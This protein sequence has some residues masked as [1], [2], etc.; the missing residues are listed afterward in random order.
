MAKTLAFIRGGLK[1]MDKEN[2]MYCSDYAYKDTRYWKC[3]SVGCNVR[4]KTL[5]LERQGPVQSVSITG[6]HPHPLNP[7]EHKLSEAKIELKTLAINSQEFSHTVI[8]NVL[9]NTSKNIKAIIPSNANFTRNVRHIRAVNSMAPPN[10]SSKYGSRFPKIY[11]ENP[12]AR[13]SFY[14]ILASTTWTDF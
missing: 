12:R 2:Y 6:T 1:L 5:N 10:P 9:K 4:A 7:M 13:T 11:L 3:S 14:L 8:D